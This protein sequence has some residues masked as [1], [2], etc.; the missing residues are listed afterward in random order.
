VFILSE[1]DLQK[2]KFK[3]AFIERYRAIL[4][5]EVENF[6]EYSR[7]PLTPTIRVNT[8]KISK[9][10]LV[11]RLTAKGWII[12]PLPWYELGF[13][14]Y[15]PKYQLG[16]AIEH[17]LG[18]F[19]MQGPASMIPPLALNPK[20][21]EIVLDM[22]A[23]PGSK[24]TQMAAMM[25]NQGIIIAN[26]TDLERIVALRGNLQRCGVINVI[27]TNMDGR[28]FGRLPQ[29]FDK[30]LL[31]A[32]CS[33]DGTIRIKPHIAEQWN[34][35]VIKGIAKLQSQLILSAFDCLVD[36]GELVYST[37][38]LNPEEDEMVVTYLLEK[39]ENAKILDIKIEN[40]KTRPGLT[41]WDKYEFPE[42]LKKT[43][44][45]YPQDNDTEGFYIARVKKVG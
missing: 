21:G 43:L 19:Y 39:R 30:V 41:E 23:A 36:G 11:E 24:T 7:K 12:E 6:I 10:E 18:Y 14:V 15:K 32:P 35:K 33:G 45:I 29:K 16:N 28:R 31:D 17:R 34:P 9:K 37:C 3:K 40:L 22:A 27:V 25:R 26:D 8:I 2:I 20:P 38:T 1:E 4:G 44:R 42:D 13:W 5:P